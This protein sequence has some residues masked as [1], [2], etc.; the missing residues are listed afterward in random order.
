MNMTII[1]PTLNAIRHFERLMESI[2]AQT[3]IPSVLF[4]DGGSTDG[5]LERLTGHDVI[6]ANGSTI[7]AAQ[8]IGLSQVADGYVYFMGADDYFENSDFVA[9]VCATEFTILHGK[10]RFSTLPTYKHMPRQQSYVYRRD[11]M[12]GFNEENLVYADMAFNQANADLITKSETQ[13]CVIEP[14]GFSSR[15]T[16][17]IAP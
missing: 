3:K 16:N 8:N 2:S 12:T 7:Y 4:V 5:T 13:F 6:K 15:H 11:V 9:T 14:G 17:R 10:C 1:I